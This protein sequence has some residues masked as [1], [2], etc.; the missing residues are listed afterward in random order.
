VADAAVTLP[1]TAI[2]PPMTRGDAC[3][4]S[5]SAS[6]HA[7]RGALE[8]EHVLHRETIER[9]AVL[10]PLQ[11]IEE[12]EPREHRKLR[13]VVVLDAFFELR[14]G[15]GGVPLAKRSAEFS[16]TAHSPDWP[17][18]PRTTRARAPTGQGLRR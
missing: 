13:V 3:G 18:R 11:K 17:A 1:V 16:S 8:L 10:R 2:E 15:V 7:G 14:P 9:D 12:R 6:S 5:P 4:L